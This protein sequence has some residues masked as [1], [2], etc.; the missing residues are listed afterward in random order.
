MKYQGSDALVRE[1]M[2]SRKYLPNQVVTHFHDLPDS[3]AYDYF[4]VGIVSKPSKGIQKVDT[5]L[6]Y[7]GKRGW[8]PSVG[9]MIDFTKD[10]QGALMV[11]P[12]K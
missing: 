8:K 3:D 7:S 12:S 4:V 9:D 2:G 5:D 6:C 11:A 1:V 10:G